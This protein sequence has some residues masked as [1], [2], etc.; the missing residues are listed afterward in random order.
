MDEC[1]E[2]IKEEVVKSRASA[3]CRDPSVGQGFGPFPKRGRCFAAAGGDALPQAWH[4]CALRVSIVAMAAFFGLAWATS[5][6]AADELS[7]AHRI[8]YAFEHGDLRRRPLSL[9]DSLAVARET[10][11]GVTIERQDFEGDFPP[12]G[13]QVLDRA[14]AQDRVAARYQWARETCEVEPLVGGR[15]AAWAVGGGSEG[16]KLGCLTAY[17]AGARVN[18][19]LS[20]VADLTAYPQGFKLRMKLLLDQPRN[21]RGSETNMQVAVIDLDTSE[22][23]AYSISTPRPLS[24]LPLELPEEDLTP[25]GGRPQVAIVIAYQDDPAWGGHLGAVVDNVIIEGLTIERTPT[26]TASA[27]PHPTAT[28][29][30]VRMLLYVP[31]ADKPWSAPTQSAAPSATPTPILMVTD[32]PTP[33]PMPSA[34]RTPVPMPTRTPTAIPMPTATRPSI[35]CRDVMIDGSFEE[36]PSKWY[37][38]IPRSYPSVRV[39]RQGPYDEAPYHG[40]WMAEIWAPEDDVC[41]MASSP[42]ATVPVERLVSAKLTYAWYG[43]TLERLPNMD[44]LLVMVADPTR[45]TDT[46]TLVK[47]YMNQDVV[48]RWTVDSVDITEHFRK[49]WRSIEVEFGGSNDVSNSTWW[50]IDAVSLEL[51]TRG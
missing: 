42:I 6:L 18:T 30:P 4:R 45:R 13:W 3:I 41:A 23:V 29:T 14:A 9:G 10:A 35:T 34:T 2:T 11:A 19:W 44:A 50:H 33:V 31:R 1:G 21:E 12:P 25:F 28:A 37:D 5:G 24:W 51:C 46:M 7:V 32:T 39:I 15:A 40:L 17:P 8:A 38:L 16:A 43:H 26:P 27:T 49:G 36:T 48:R 20:Y 22:G 47:G